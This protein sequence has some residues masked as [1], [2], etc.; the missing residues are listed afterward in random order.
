MNFFSWLF[1]A[2]VVTCGFLFGIKMARTCGTLLLDD[3][4]SMWQPSPRDY[5]NFGMESW[6][7]IA[8]KYDIYQHAMSTYVDH[9]KIERKNIEMDI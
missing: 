6:H 2:W 1:W 9:M 4:S 3:V 5:V 7:P 8:K